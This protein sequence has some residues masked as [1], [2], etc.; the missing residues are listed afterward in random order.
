MW[1][2]AETVLIQDGRFLMGSESG[3]PDELP[4]HEVELGRFWIGKYTVT[5]GLWKRVAGKLPEK[6][7]AQDARLPLVEV[8]WYEAVA[9]C[10]ALSRDQGLECCYES[11][12]KIVEWKKT[13]DG[14]RLPTEAEWEYAARGGTTSRGTLY[15]GSDNLDEVAWYLGNSGRETHPVGTKGPNGLGLYDMSGNVYEYCWDVYG[16]YANE[17]IRNPVGPTPKVANAYRTIRGGN[18]F[19]LGYRVRVTSR[20][21]YGFMGY[22]HD[23]IGFRVARGPIEAESR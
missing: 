22:T 11:S 1:Q 13:S 9:F 15:S 18:C 19:G 3:D 21:R 2:E 6:T 12:G 17:L 7:R 4:V 14:Y 16:P 8:S 20:R 5:Q 23:F 10:N